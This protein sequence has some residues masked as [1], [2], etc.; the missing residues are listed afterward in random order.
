MLPVF[1]KTV[2][3]F[4]SSLESFGE[5]LLSSVDWPLLSL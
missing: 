1:L 3:V 5:T 2:F 4:V